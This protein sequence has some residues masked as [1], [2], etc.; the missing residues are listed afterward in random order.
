MGKAGYFERAMGDSCQARANLIQWYLEA[1]EFGLLLLDAHLNVLYMNAGASLLLTQSDGLLL[2]GDTLR[3][4]RSNGSVALAQYLG[5]IPDKCS[6]LVRQVFRPSGKRPYLLQIAV[7][8]ESSLCQ[9]RSQTDSDPLSVHTCASFLASIT[10]PDSVV[11]IPKGQLSEL[12]GLTVR[13]ATLAA[14]I[15]QGVSVEN[16]AHQLKVTS[17]TVRFHLRSIF[18]KT[19]TSGQVE[20]VRLLLSAP[21]LKAIHLEEL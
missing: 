20:L 21:R 7:V 14:M 9:G 3:V 10:D 15:V 12:Y 1:Q 16:I 17:N 18:R 6:L 5:G 2:R 11:E 8:G 4:Q 19:H 13:E